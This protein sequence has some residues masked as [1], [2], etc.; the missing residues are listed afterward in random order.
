MALVDRHDT[1]A[2]DAEEIMK[3]PAPRLEI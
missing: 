3:A 2:G 1:E